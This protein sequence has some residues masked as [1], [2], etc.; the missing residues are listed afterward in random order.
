MKMHHTGPMDRR[1]VNRL[2]RLD[3]FL[4]DTRFQENIIPIQARVTVIA[5]YT[6]AIASILAIPFNIVLDL[7]NMAYHLVVV[8]AVYLFLI[9]AGLASFW[10][11]RSLVVIRRVFSLAILILSVGLLLSDGGTR[12]LGFFYFIAGYS[13]LFYVLGFAGGIAMP[14]FILVGGGIRVLLG[15][16]SEQSYLSDGYFANHF[17]VI[18]AMSTVLGV[19]SVVYQDIVVRYL[20]R[21][22][23]LDELT[24]MPSRKRLDLFI[25][26]RVRRR[27]VTGTPFSLLGIKIAQFAKVNSFQGSQFA[28]QVLSIV[29][30]RIREAAAPHGFMARYTGTVF[31]MIVEETDFLALES[32][33]TTLLDV[34][35][36]RIELEGRS[37][38]LQAN[39][40]ITRSPQ[41]GLDEDTLIANLMASFSRMR[42]QPGFVVFFDESLHRAEA[43]RFSLMSELRG[44][45]E[46]NELSLAYHPQIRLANGN[47]EG[48]EI[49][50]RWNSRAFGPVSPE[51]FI[52]LAEEAGLIQEI[53]RWVCRTTFA[54]VRGILDGLAPGQELPVYALNLSPLDL[55]DP[56]FRDLM[57]QLPVEFDVP[58]A[59]IEFEITEGV[60]MDENPVVQGNLEQIIKSGF[61]LAIDDFG[62]GYSSLSYLHRL[63]AQIL[64][65]DRSFIMQIGEDRPSSPIVEAVISMARSLHLE[66]VAEGVETQM[67]VDY[68]RSLG[69]TFAQGWYYAKPMPLA[70]YL[71]WLQARNQPK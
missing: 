32:I 11:T 10:T 51:E 49:L 57:R 39:V 61:R 25:Q 44:A 28:D 35:Q 46:Q 2:H 16:F 56:G 59:A 47:C 4:F 24:G 60:M 31:L 38:G 17:L 29:G 67:Q 20:Y 34:V 9:V 54:A 45:I 22:A 52:P 50:L 1:P 37:V 69:C 62:T 27:R 55:A 23:Y 21:V 5:L 36:K 42:N 64:K 33:G 8:Q 15:G 7:G 6:M 48:A 70:D 19:F 66:I 12:G 3:H 30:S 65:I 41:D 18:L 40:A 13:V 58:Q 53:T 63:R 26:E 43:R 71:Q 68:L 14:I